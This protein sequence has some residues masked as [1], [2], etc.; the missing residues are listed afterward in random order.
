M[1]KNEILTRQTRQAVQLGFEKVRSKS[2]NEKLVVI[3]IFVLDDNS[4]LFSAFM[5]FII[6]IQNNISE[7][8]D[9]TIL[10]CI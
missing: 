7:K 8:S 4:R 10:L 5:Y 2:I 6:I 3:N 1:L 9:N